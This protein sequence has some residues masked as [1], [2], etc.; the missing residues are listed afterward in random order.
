MAP[1]RPMKAQRLAEGPR[2]AVAGAA[3]AQPQRTAAQAAARMRWRKPA[4]REA[5]AAAGGDAVSEEG[6]C[7]RCARTRADTRRPRRGPVLDWLEAHRLPVAERFAE[8]RVHARASRFGNLRIRQELKQH[9]VALSDRGRPGA[10]GQSELERAAAVLERKFAEPP[11]TSLPSARGRRAISRRARL[12]ARGDPAGPASR[13]CRATCYIRRL[14]C[15]LRRRHRPA[16]AAARHHR[17]TQPTRRTDGL[18]DRRARASAQAPPR[19]RRANLRTGQR[20]RG[21]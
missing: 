20:L 17:S 6:Q 15:K 9:Q 5:E 3:R 8:S 13:W 19:H 1:A 2:A 16:C 10:Q 21:K 18:A 11:A 12:L 14:T 7:R 4:A